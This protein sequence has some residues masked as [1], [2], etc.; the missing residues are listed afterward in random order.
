[1][2]VVK[3]DRGSKYVFLNFKQLCKK[4]L[5]SDHLII[6]FSFEKF[7]LIIKLQNVA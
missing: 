2:Q 5:Q 6:Y 7:S 4:D 3:K 1:M